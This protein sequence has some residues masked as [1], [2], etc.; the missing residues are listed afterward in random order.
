LLRSKVGYALWSHL[1]FL[2]VATYLVATSY[3]IF[4]GSDAT[5]WWALSIH[6][7]SVGTVGSLIAHRCYKRSHAAA[8]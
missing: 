4:T 6:I 7:A 1:Q 3:D 5:S 2:T 8:L